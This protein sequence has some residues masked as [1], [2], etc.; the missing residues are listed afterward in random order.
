MVDLVVVEVVDVAAAA[1]G[2]TAVADE[3]VAGGVVVDVIDGT[4]TDLVFQVLSEME[5]EGENARNLARCPSVLL[6]SSPLRCVSFR[7]RSLDTSGHFAR[8]RLA[9]AAAAAV[10]ES[11]SYLGYHSCS[12]SLA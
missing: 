9:E 5:G 1:V 3:D 12:S 6:L 4:L 8:V 11:P 10:D 2:V 7:F